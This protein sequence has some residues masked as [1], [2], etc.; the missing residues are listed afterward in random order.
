MEQIFSITKAAR[1]LANKEKQTGVEAEA[2]TR[3]IEQAYKS[4]SGLMVPMPNA[5]YIP[6]G[7]RAALTAG[8]STANIVQGAHR[9]FEFSL[10]ADCVLAQ[11]GARIETGLKGDDHTPTSTLPSVSWEGE[12]GEASAGEGTISKG[13]VCKPKRMTAV[14]EFS[15]QLLAQSNRS[16]DEYVERSIMQVIATKLEEAIFAKEISSYH[17]NGMFTTSPTDSGDL[18]F[19]RFIAMEETLADNN[20]LKGN[21]AY[22]I[23]P[24]LSIK[25]KKTLKHPTGAGGFIINDNSTLNGYPCFAT[26][27]V[28][29][30][31]QG[32]AAI[33][34]EGGET[35][36]AAVTDEEGNITTPAVICEGGEVVTA[37]V[38][39][40]EYGAILGNWQ[41]Y[42]IL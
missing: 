42:F 39:G 18:S 36:T 24:K 16:I 21:L 7:T 37:A 13:T 9:P 26:N 8:N 4:H 38:L 40:T 5:L 31:L 30:Q 2:L 22:I 23:H 35:L 19:E 34:C 14:L 41:D 20:A 27:N 11:A 1:A 28:A 33:L 25:A 15:K 29:S 3:G 32:T 12:T 17:S 6:V 10:S